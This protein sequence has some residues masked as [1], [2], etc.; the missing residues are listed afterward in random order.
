MQ[1]SSCQSC[2]K[3]CHPLCACLSE[4]A[5]HSTE[6]CTCML[7]THELHGCMQM[8]ISQFKQIM[9]VWLL[10][11]LLCL[12]SIQASLCSAFH[13]QQMCWE[14]GMTQMVH[15]HATYW[16]CWFIFIVAPLDYGA[17]PADIQGSPAPS[18]WPAWL[19]TAFWLLNPP[20]ETYFSMDARQFIQM[21][22]SI[23]NTS[24]V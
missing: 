18:V 23:A 9:L 15:S 7:Q 16:T 6:Q 24:E 2:A 1:R 22:K 14:K 8:E 21:S 3:H 20:G 19:H 12:W 13:G 10:I 4:S 5:C 11:E 17:L